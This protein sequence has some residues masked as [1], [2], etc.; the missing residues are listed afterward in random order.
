MATLS[1]YTLHPL[2]S[3]SSSSTL[4]HLSPCSSTSYLSLPQ[5]TSLSKVYCPSS[6]CR[7]KPTKSRFLMIID[8]VL[9]FNGF[10]STFYFDTQTLLATVSVLAAIALSLFLG[11]KGDPVS[12]E[13]CGG[14][15]GTKCVFCNDGKMKQETG[16]VDCKVCKGSGLILCKKC[17]GSGY[18]R[19]L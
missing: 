7:R 9:L 11:L 12:C 16:L 1:H 19:R 15:G 14:N 5:P 6:K 2:S 17:A 4:I 18:S 3:S 10:G 13:R 8:P